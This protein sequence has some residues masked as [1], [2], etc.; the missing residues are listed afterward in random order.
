MPCIASTADAFK[1]LSWPPDEEEEETR[2]EVSFDLRIRRQDYGRGGNAI[3]SWLVP[4]LCL[5][6]LTL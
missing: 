2:T 3:F 4:W 6:P 5:A 1:V